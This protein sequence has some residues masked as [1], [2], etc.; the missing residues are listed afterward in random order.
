MTPAQAARHW[1]EQCEI[2]DM[3]EMELLAYMA[4]RH[5]M[6]IRIAILADRFDPVRTYHWQRLKGGEAASLLRRVA[7]SCEVA[8]VA[9]I[10]ED[11]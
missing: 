9:P 8:P 5:Q 4:G 2:H 11:W 1:A 6:L 3:I 10:V 7:D